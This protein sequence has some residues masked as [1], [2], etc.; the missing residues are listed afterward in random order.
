MLDIAFWSIDDKFLTYISNQ[1]DI[2]FLKVK[3]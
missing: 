3:N 2:E 1:L